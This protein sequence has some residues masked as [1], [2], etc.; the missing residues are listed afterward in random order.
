MCV[1]SEHPKA[2]TQDLAG[3]RRPEATSAMLQA[4]A[5]SLVRTLPPFATVRPG[6]LMVSLQIIWIP[7][8]DWSVLAGRLKG[9]HRK[10]RLCIPP[11]PPQRG[12]RLD[13]GFP[14]TGT[15]AGDHLH[16]AAQLVGSDRPSTL[17]L[18]EKLSLDDATMRVAHGF[19]VRPLRHRGGKTSPGR[20]PPQ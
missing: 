11:Y 18:F 2:V 5:A 20:V 3:T 19:K 10:G 17:P 13:A 6:T 8:W 12:Q 7:L 4:I 9:Q 15:H 1:H 14:G 16:T